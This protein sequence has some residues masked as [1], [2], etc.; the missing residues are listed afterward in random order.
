MKRSLFVACLIVSFLP[1]VSNAAILRNLKLGDRGSDVIELQQTLNQDS[2]TIVAAS[3]PGSPGQETSYFGPATRA[4]VMKFQQKHAA[5]VLA[6]GGLTLPTGFVGLYTRLFLFRFVNSSG[7][8]ETR[9]TI[10]ETAAPA[11]PIG[12]PPEI[13]SISPSVVTRSTTGM[14]ITGLNFAATGNS[15]LISSEDLDGYTGLSSVDGK[16]LN[17]SLHLAIADALKKQLAPLITSGRYSA[18][19]FSIAKNIQERTSSTGNAQIPV[20]VVV[21][22]AN[23]ASKPITLLIDITEILKEIGE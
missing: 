17:F 2:D 14:I 3:G 19:S 7:A 6:P 13:I 23:G 9:G 18:I 5:D 11:A 8:V 15:V 21:R 1:I 10:A 20:T 4:A 16:N 22:N 12:P